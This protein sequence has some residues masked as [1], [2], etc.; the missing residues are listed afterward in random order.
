MRTFIAIELE[1]EV[2]DA[3]EG[4]QQQAAELCLQGELH[5]EGKFPSDPAF[6]G[7]NQ[8]GRSGRCGTGYD[9]NHQTES[10]L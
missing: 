8:T 7:G 6:S 1:E 10:P 5:T 2:K 9:G 3:L 4:A